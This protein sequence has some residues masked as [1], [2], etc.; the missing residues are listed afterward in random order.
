MN[1]Y[2]HTQT[3][4]KPRKAG[5]PR[6]QENPAKLSKRAR[7]DF[8]EGY[9]E[10]DTIKKYHLEQLLRQSAN[11]SVVWVER[12]AR[13]ARIAQANAHFVFALWDL[14]LDLEKRIPTEAELEETA[15]IAM[16]AYFLTPAE[17]NWRTELKSLFYGNAYFQSVR[18]LFPL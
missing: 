5:R 17:W 10:I 12:A 14:I 3:T 15:N 6:K 16:K 9:T 4:E 7:T 13:A 1:T 2:T 8:Y 18:E 11:K